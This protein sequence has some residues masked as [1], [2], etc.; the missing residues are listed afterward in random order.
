MHSFLKCR[1]ESGYTLIEALFQLLIMAVLL[2]FVVLFLYWKMP[3]ERQLKDYYETEWEL[4]AIEL[5]SLLV[6]V[7]NFDVLIGNRA[8]SFF[9]DRGKIHVEQNGYVIRK[10]VNESGHVPLF[11]N[12][13]NVFFAQDE[14]ELNVEVTML[15]GR[16]RE[17]R[18]VIGMHQ[19]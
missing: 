11:T 4:F 2:H 16:K 17:R 10:R 14:H 3:V 5:Q 18:F 15:D 19:E 6:D 9:N 13:S 8:V 1:N 7:E 12:V